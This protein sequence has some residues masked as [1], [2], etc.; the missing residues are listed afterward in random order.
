MVFGGW[1]SNVEV[2]RKPEA[3]TCG[4][5]SHQDHGP[6]S[7]RSQS[8]SAVPEQVVGSGVQGLKSGL[9]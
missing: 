9:Q 4:L 8:A 2:V 7:V 1:A 6:R 5:C 3:L